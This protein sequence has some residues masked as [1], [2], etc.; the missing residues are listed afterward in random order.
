M[1]ILY[2]ITKSELG[3]AQVH[4]HQ[5]IK[6]FAQS[7]EVALVTG[8]QGFLTEATAR[9]NVKTY[10]IHSLSNSTNPLS[11]IRCIKETCAIIRE[12]KPDIIHAHS[13]KAGMIGRLCGLLYSVPVVFTAHGWSFSQGVPRI[14]RLAALCAEWLCGFMPSTVISVS[15][16]D[17]G[18]AARFRIT[19][20]CPS[21]VIHNGLPTH[22]RIE[23][24]EAHLGSSGFELLMVARFTDQK[25][26]GLLLDAMKL[27]PEW[28]T[29]TFVGDG[30]TF[31]KIK[32]KSSH[33]NLDARVNF[34][35][36]SNDIESYL[37]N[38][39]CFVLISNYEGLPI[40][41]L[42]A[43]RARLPVI[44]SNVGGIREAVFDGVTGLLV[45]DDPANIANAIL[46]VAT[47]ALLAQK[48]GSN[49]ASEFSRSFSE[50]TMIQKVNEIYLSI[51]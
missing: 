6:K 23:A 11:E 49:G 10:V 48:F 31:N 2:I 7:C 33:N 24:S 8:G 29:L 37:K 27:L 19:R 35:G 5:L 44:A 40:S 21:I 45:N 38:S 46:S 9:I 3:G 41:I 42:E 25:N 12:F 13:T 39:S 15:H 36:E 4:V 50:S 51:V 14:R 1:K 26:H 28:I 34:V 18:I 16:Y 20:N 17:Q 47:D 43:M 30:P 22:S 32:A